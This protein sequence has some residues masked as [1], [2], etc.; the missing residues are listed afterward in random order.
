MGGTPVFR[1]WF[2]PIAA[3]I[4]RNTKTRNG[5]IGFSDSSARPRQTLRRSLMRGGP[6]KPLF[7]ATLGVMLSF[8]A[9]QACVPLPSE[10]AAKRLMLTAVNAVRAEAGL[11]PLSPSPTLEAVAEGH[12]CDMAQRDYFSHQSPDGTS[13]VHRLRA[14]GYRMRA[15]VEN[16]AATSTTDPKSVV[17]MWRGSPGH[18][19]NLVSPRVD[20]VGFGATVGAAGTYWVMVGASGG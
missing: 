7:L 16:I 8:G 13:L 12:A 18:F 1:S 4:I 20:Q 2:N 19:A 6:M 10:T 14:G 3:M 17:R 15:A 11:G 9:A 5:C